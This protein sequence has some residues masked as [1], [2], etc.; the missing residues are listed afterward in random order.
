[1]ARTSYMLTEA[2]IRRY[3]VHL[4]EQER[5]VNT[6]QKYVYSLHKLQRYLNG[7]PVTKMALIGW[8]EQLMQTYAPASTNTMLGIAEQLSIV[9]GLGMDWERNR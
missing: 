2:W 5:A 8:K 3:A 4:M 6:I 7:T 9:Y 1:M